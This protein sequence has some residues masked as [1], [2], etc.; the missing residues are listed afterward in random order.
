MAHLGLSS[1]VYLDTNIF[2]CALEGYQ[3]FRPV[4]T[5]LFDARDKNTLTAVTTM[6]TL[7]EVLACMQFLAN[8]G[9]ILPC[10]VSPPYGCPNCN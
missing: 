5:T 6:L 1:L 8:D 2:I 9:R 10:L 3:V 4:L 7:A